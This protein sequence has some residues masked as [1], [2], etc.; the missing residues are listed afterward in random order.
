MNRQRFNESL[1]SYLKACTETDW[2]TVG[3]SYKFR[4][5][6]WL[7][8]RVDFNRHTDEE[9]LK[10]CLDSQNEKYDGQTKG[11]NFLISSRRFGK[12]VIDIRDIK[13][14]RHLFNGGE[15]KKEIMTGTLP[16]TK[17][18]VWLGTMIPEKFN[19]C[20]KVDLIHSLEYLFDEKGLPQKG[21]DSFIIAQELLKIVRSEFHKEADKFKSIFSSFEEIRDITPVIEVWLVQDFIFYIR[22][23]IL[24]DSEMFTWVPAFEELAAK[25][26]TMR[27]DQPGIVERLIRS[28][29]TVGFND[30]DKNNQTI[31]LREIDPFTVFAS[32][33]KFGIEKVLE[34]MPSIIRN[35]GL[36][37]PVPK[38]AVGIPKTFPQNVWYFSFEKDRDPQVIPSLWDLFEQAMQGELDENL[39]S[40]VL[41]FP[42]VGISKLTGGFYKAQPNKYLTIDRNTVFYLRNIGVSTDIR[43]LQD[44]NKVIAEAKLNTN[45][46]LYEISHVAYMENVYELEGPGEVEEEVTSYSSKVR[47]WIYAPGSSARYWDLYY[48]EGIMGLGPNELG[49]LKRYESRESIVEKLRELRNPEG[50]HKND[51][52]G[53]WQFLKLMK[54]GDIIIAKKGTGIFLGYG[55]VE[56]EYYYDPNR[57]DYH[58]LR[59]VKW[60]KKGEWPEIKGKIVLKG[61]TDVTKYP[62]YTSR[63]KELLGINETETQISIVK[64]IIIENTGTQYWWLNANQKYWNIDN[65]KI[66]QVQTYTTHNEAGN[67]RRIYDYFKQLKPGDLIIGYQTTPSL[68][69]KAL[70]EVTNGISEDEEGREI[71]SFIIK[72]FFPY[73]PTWE[74]LKSNDQVN[75]SEVFVN[76]Q[77]SLFKLSKSEFESIVDLCRQGKAEELETYNIEDALEE[78]FIN[79]DQLKSILELLGYKKNI[80]LQGPPG[81]GKTFLAKRLAYLCTGYKDKERIEMVQFHQSY[82]YEDFIQGY[83][84]CEGNSFSLRNGVFYEFCIRA[85]RDPG[86]DYFFIIDEINRGNLGKIFGELMML[87]EHDKRGKEFS[88]RLTYSDSDADKFFI[89]ENLFIIGTMNTADRSLA[90]VDYA[91]RRRFVFIDLKPAFKHPGFDKL[92]KS[93]HVLPSVIEKIKIRMDELNTV[94]SGDDN[95][96][97]WFSIGHSYFCSHRNNH[98][99]EWYKHIINNEIGP[100]LREYWFDDEQKAEENI[101]KLLRV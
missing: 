66:G 71:I 79:E 46:K 50:S 12:E 34:L 87:I 69:V 58:H 2:F 25:L 63:L 42:G 21:F 32:I 91:L 77:G 31:Q 14:I 67:K 54:P 60:M 99:E 37:S 7:H 24:I 49:D 6:K 95:L 72:E 59:K 96:G 1:Q 84:P 23:K 15:L 22:Y 74:E 36:N 27:N 9:I 13:I 78:I 97:K 48:N 11:L 41:K 10:I 92:L 53:S 28:G 82:S 57:N 19:T 88:I 30:I 18:S 17:F 52:L 8:S 56:S 20:P 85:Q 29:I 80:I 16:L 47:Y 4:F 40:R 51:S 33:T 43:T 75:T 93:N 62:E 38:D 26:L 101:K 35:F 64:P 83:R 70:F 100:L 68:K 98:D 55:V 39:F 76:N 73:Q 5:A 61:L 3:E 44:Y 94:I 89:P 86:N 45:M 81:T 90:I 65:Y